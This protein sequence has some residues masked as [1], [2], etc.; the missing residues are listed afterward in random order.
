[1]G[2]DHYPEEWGNPKRL[3]CVCGNELPCPLA[4]PSCSTSMNAITPP[5]IPDKFTLFAQA[6][7]KAAEEHGIAEFEMK[8]RP[9]WNTRLGLDRRING[10]MQIIY[11]STDGRGRPSVG[12]S[13]VL[14]STL[15]LV[16]ENDPQSA[17]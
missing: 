1:M 10:D 2:S 3:T 8:F 17:S 16:I 5:S 14:N 4:P 11:R 6:V 12:L 15:E 13:I 9:E 7:A